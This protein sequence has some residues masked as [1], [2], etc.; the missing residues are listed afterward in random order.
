MLD[1]KVAFSL[2]SLYWKQQLSLMP[3]PERLQEYWNN[4]AHFY[5]SM[6]AGK[7]LLTALDAL[8]W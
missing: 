3:Q 4:L 2:D 7:E 6:M 1:T 5:N 8:Y